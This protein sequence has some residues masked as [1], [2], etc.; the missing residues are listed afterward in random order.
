MHQLWDEA[1]F[2]QT[3]LLILL[4]LAFHANDEGVCQISVSE[5]ARSARCSN[6]WASGVLTALEHDGWLRR[7]ISPGR[8]TTYRITPHPRTTV[9]A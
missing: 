8:L 4:N 6:R 7:E 9:Q 3:T 1:P 2:E 5:L